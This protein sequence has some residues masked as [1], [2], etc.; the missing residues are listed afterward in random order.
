MPTSKVVF[1]GMP[2]LY[3]GVFRIWRMPTKMPLVFFGRKVV[4]L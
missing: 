2:T 1:F 4:F 3:G